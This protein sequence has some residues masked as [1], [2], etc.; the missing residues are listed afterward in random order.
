MRRLDGIINAMDM[1][2]S[3]L[4]EIVKDREVW[5]AEVHGVRVRTWLRDWT[6]TTTVLFLNYGNWRKGNL[7]F[8]IITCRRRKAEF[9]LGREFRF[10]MPVGSSVTKIDFIPLFYFYWKKKNKTKLHSKTKAV[11][12]TQKKKKCSILWYHLEISCDHNMNL[13][14]KIS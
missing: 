9:S 11:L 6:T 2:L 3:K 4:W 14:L 1:S 7:S 12:K 5:S 10:H 8:R 13:F